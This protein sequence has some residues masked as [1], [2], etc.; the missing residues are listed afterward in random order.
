M[1]FLLPLLLLFMFIDQELAV[2]KSL[3]G[4]STSHLFVQAIHRG[5]TVP[6]AHDF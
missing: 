5:E 2:A 6:L 3:L 4:S 1:V